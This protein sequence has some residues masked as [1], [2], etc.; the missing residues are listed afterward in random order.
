MQS[1][2]C[3]ILDATFG[4][5]FGISTFLVVIV[6]TVLLIIRKCGL[7]K[8]GKWLCF[9]TVLFKKGNGKGTFLTGCEGWGLR[10]LDHPKTLGVLGR[11]KSSHLEW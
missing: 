11:D 2:I 1:S 10:G 6:L 8:Y 4:A 5:A 3:V 9:M 7:G